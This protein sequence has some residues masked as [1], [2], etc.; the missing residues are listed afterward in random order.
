MDGI[1][2]RAMAKVT[3]RANLNRLVGGA[4]EE[5]IISRVGEGIVTTVGSSRTHKE[6]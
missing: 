4:G 1:E 5:T 3:V 2:I 6:V